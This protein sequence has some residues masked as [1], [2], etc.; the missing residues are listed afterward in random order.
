MRVELKRDPWWRLALISC[1]S[2]DWP[3]MV[4]FMDLPDRKDIIKTLSEIP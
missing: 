4:T 2:E 1:A 3:L